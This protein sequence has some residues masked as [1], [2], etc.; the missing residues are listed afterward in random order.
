[1]H[2]VEA[3]CKELNIGQSFIAGFI[4]DNWHSNKETRKILRELKTEYQNIPIMILESIDDC[5]QIANAIDIEDNEVVEAF[6]LWSLTRSRIRELVTTYLEGEV[7]LDDNLVTK[8][9]IR[10]Y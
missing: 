4:L 6:Y 1:M 9:I 8:K 10:R 2:H 7:S 3:R 5:L